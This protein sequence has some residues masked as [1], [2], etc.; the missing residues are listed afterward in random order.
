VV[1]VSRVLN[2]N[3]RVDPAIR[4]LVLQTAAK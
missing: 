3:G 1:T 2:G 4:D